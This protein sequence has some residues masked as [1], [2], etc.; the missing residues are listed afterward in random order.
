MPTLT[1][2]SFTLNLGIIQLQ[3]ELS[4]ADRQSAWELYTEI[5]TRVAVSGK[6]NDVDGNNFTGEIYIESLDSLHKFFLEA[7][8]IMRRFPV[9]R[10]NRDNHQHLGNMIN[11]A[12]SQVLRPFLEKWQ[13]KYRHWWHNESD[14]RLSPAE[15]QG[16]FPELDDF[17]R[18]WASVRWLMRK[19]QDELIEVYSLVNIGSPIVSQK[20]ASHVI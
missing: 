15:R 12:I 8:A 7:R 5:S 13:V 20:L 9:G 17:L 11:N 10:I 1:K 14:P 16:A 6:Q 4:D 19:L 2:G 3:G 18:D